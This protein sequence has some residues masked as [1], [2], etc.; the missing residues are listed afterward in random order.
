VDATKLFLYAILGVIGLAYFMY[1][2]KQRK[3]VAAIAGI[4]IASF[5]YFT[6]NLYVIGISAIILMI[7][8]FYVRY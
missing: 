5:P 2:K 3:G 6:D 1:G 7:L 4:V 8:P